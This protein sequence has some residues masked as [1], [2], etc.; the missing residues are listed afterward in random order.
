MKRFSISFFTAAAVLAAATSMLQSQP[1][2]TQQLEN[3]GFSNLLEMQ[4]GRN[5]PVQEFEDRSLVFPEQRS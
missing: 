4:S 5:L 2:P 3:A 1:L